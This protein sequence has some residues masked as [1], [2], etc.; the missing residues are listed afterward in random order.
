MNSKSTKT[1]YMNAKIPE[2]IIRL[3]DESKKYIEILKTILD[4]K[5]V[6]SIRDNKEFFAIY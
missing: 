4:I 6:Q 5:N 1:Y 2:I 3:K